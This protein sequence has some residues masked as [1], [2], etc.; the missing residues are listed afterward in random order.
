LTPA[1]DHDLV[2][3]KMLNSNSWK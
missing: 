2:L 3:A 1:P